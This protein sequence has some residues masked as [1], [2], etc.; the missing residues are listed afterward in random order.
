MTHDTQILLAVIF[1]PLGIALM[2]FAA[3]WQLYI[4]FTETYSLDRYKDD[5]KLVWVVAALF[6]SFSLAVYYFCPNARKKGKW[7]WLAGISGVLMFGL[8]QAWLPPKKDPALMQAEYAVSLFTQA[9]LEHDGDAAAAKN[10]AEARQGVALNTAQLSLWTDAPTAAA[11]QW[12][13]LKNRYVLV[14]QADACRIFVYKADSMVLRQVLQ[15]QA[16]I[17]AAE[18]ALPPQGAKMEETY[19]FRHDGQVRTVHLQTNNEAQTPYQA[20]LD[21]MISP[22]EKNE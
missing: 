11:W 14:T 2:T 18:K 22:T 3:L 20:R 13:A 4:M 5:R 10:W 8:A 7:F 12:D 17:E 16:G 9:C 6:F 15:Q 21:L 19:V 1:I